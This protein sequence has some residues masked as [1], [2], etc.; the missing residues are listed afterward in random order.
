MVSIDWQ[1]S[2]HLELFHTWQN[3]PRVAQGWNESG[4]VEHHRNY[5]KKMHNDPHQ[6]AILAYFEA[7]PFAYFEV[8][9]AKVSSSIFLV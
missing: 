7:T 8:Y 1:N 6:I 5:L 4:T 3:D 2:E 9:W